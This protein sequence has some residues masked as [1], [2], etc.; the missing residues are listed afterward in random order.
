MSLSTDCTALKS[1]ALLLRGIDAQAPPATPAEVARG[2]DDDEDRA[3]ASSRLGEDEEDDDKVQESLQEA[4]FLKTFKLCGVESENSL[5]KSPRRLG[6][7]EFLR[8]FLLQ[9]YYT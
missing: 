9:S 2:D 3:A 6:L 5:E 1:E 8:F 7:Q 4:M